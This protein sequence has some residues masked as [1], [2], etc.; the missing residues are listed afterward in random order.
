MAAY[1]LPHVSRLVLRPEATA[2]IVLATPVGDQEG[3][4][5]LLDNLSV[6]T[7]SGFLGRCDLD[8]EQ[9]RAELGAARLGW[10]VG[11]RR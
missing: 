5:V 1:R 7:A 11:L 3:V 6:A 8:G 10:R 4:R 2:S 9:V